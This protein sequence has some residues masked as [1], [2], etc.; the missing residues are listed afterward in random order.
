MRRC[1]RLRLL[2]VRPLQLLLLFGLSLF[3][4][5]HSCRWELRTV[6]LDEG[7]SILWKLDE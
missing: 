4:S 2:F 6:I 7:D 3:M 5:V 1:Y